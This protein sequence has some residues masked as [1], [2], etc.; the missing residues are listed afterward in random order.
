M[1]KIVLLITALMATLG[2][3]AQ[4]QA[5]N[6]TIDTAEQ[7]AV[8][9]IIGYLSHDSV[10]SA[11]PQYAAVQLQIDTLRQAYQQEM[12]RVEDEFNQKYETFLEQRSQYPR[13]ILLKR[14]QE[15]QDMLQQNI[16]FRNRGLEDLREAETLAL[17]PLRSQLS[18]AI[19][20]VAQQLHLSVVLNTD[21]NTTLYLDPS[22]SVDITPQVLSVMNDE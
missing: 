6:D 17:R 11:M 8:F 14:Q 10:L 13:T 20:T 18:S 16:D 12:K 22:M 21:Q 7:P 15:L 2:A 9:V 1:K 19:A 3:L 5:E 4:Q